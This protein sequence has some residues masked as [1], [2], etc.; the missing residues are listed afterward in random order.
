MRRLPDVLDHVD[1]VE[2]HGDLHAVSG[3]ARLHE[4]ELR[5]GAVDEHDPALDALGVVA[6]SFQHRF[7]VSGHEFRKE[8]ECG[9]AA[10]PTRCSVC[11]HWRRR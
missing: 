6:L 2:D 9:S 5:L 8:S 11:S 7:G 3:D 10:R 1:D 4:V